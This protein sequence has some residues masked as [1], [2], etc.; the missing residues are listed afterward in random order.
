LIVFHDARSLGSVDM[1][2]V[3]SSCHRRREGRAAAWACAGGVLQDGT[4]VPRCDGV[5]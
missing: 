1:N 4:G 5:P 3:Q 2:V